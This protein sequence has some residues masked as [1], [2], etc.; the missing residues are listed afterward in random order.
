MY[1]TSSIFHISQQIFSYSIKW[2]SIL[3]CSVG[4]AQTFNG[5]TGVITDN[6]TNINFNCNVSG[7]GNLN[8]TFGLQS[9]CLSISHS[10]LEDIEGKLIAPDGTTIRLFVRIGY[11]SQNF[12]NTCFIQ[13]ASTSIF[14]GTPPYTGSFKPQDYLGLIN[15]GQNGN[16]TWRLQIRDYATPD[17]GNV[18]SWSLT[19]GNTPAQPF[20]SN[21]PII[22][23]NS[24]SN[25]IVDEPKV[26]ADL[27]VY[28][29]ATGRNS[30]ADNPAY[31]GKVGIELRGSSS[32]QFPKRSY[33]LEL[34]DA[35]G[36][37]IDT[38]L[39]GLPPESDWSL[40]ANYT[41]KSLM[42]NMLAYHLF[43]EMG[44]YAPGTKYCEVFVNN[45]YRGLYLLTE[46]IKRDSNRV[47]IS[48]LLP[49]DTAGA[50]V[51][52]GY[53]IKIDKT[54]GSGIGGWTSAYSSP[55]PSNKTINFLYEYPSDIN[56]HPKQATYIQQVMTAFENT[57]NGPNYNNP[58]SG[59]RSFFKI[60]NLLDY[61][62]LNE[63]SRN[64]DGLRISTFI[65]KEKSTDGNKMGFVPWDYDIAFGNADYCNGSD[66]TQ[67]AYNFPQ[68]CASD[69][70]QV[71]FWWSRFMQ[72]DGFKDNARCR[73]ETFRTSFL[74]DANLSSFIDSVASVLQEAQERNFDTYP[75]LG[76]YVW[77]NPYP[78]PADYAGEV[79]ELKT[80][81]MAR[82]KWLDNNL[83]GN[84]L[85]TSVTQKREKSTNQVLLFPNPFQKQTEVYW[86]SP[87]S[88]TARLI[89]M[90]HMGASLMDIE[91]TVHAGE[92]NH[93]ISL[94]GF[95]PGIYQLILQQGTMKLSSSLVKY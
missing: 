80:W 72:D 57:M 55:S 23:I 48:K 93:T 31:A 79:N 29:K 19:F 69:N 94:D 95:A 73:Y 11:S 83:P 82:L 75:I 71:P 45:Q 26:M 28:D 53:I 8:G 5:A 87:E 20:S 68:V 59:Y 42:N 2:L 60:T 3:L 85:N 34:W 54:T 61:F 9:I 33:G 50:E 4:I 17:Q 78:I 21:L 36:L 44:H 62:L 51:T 43:R 52:G 40:I 16:G 64:V 13:T 7:I 66:T 91:L 77:P 1:K 39:L 67:W 86:N 18:L 92:N 15:N 30:L 22:K 76:T 89:V 81:L 56:I 37:A 6:N 74:S 24:G 46:K 70:N 25:S 58:L 84:C 14:E 88:G 10:Y 38:G 41:D 90:N 63:I 35:N 49:I 12:T 32:S 47:S 27:S 65:Y